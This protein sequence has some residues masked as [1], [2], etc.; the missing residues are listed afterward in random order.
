MLV[1]VRPAIFY[2]KASV[3]IVRIPTEV[4][5]KKKKTTAQRLGEI[6]KSDV[7]M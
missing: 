3:G 5:L 4:N 1:Y 2:H 7:I 6:S